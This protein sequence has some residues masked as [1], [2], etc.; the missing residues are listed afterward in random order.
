MEIVI[1]GGGL[2]G[3]A[4]GYQLSRLGARRITIIEREPTCGFHSSGRNAAM[5]RQITPLPQVTALASASV[6]FFSSPPADWQTQLA[7]RQTG[8]LLLASGDGIAKLEREAAYAR[9]CGIPVEFWSPERA[10]AHVPPLGGAVFE[11]AV[12]SP[13]DGVLDVHALLEGYL[14]G[15]RA[16]GGRVATALTVIGFA[17]EG[18]RITA[19][20][21]TE[22]E[23]RAD[24]V[25]NAAGAWAGETGHLA[26]AASV[27]L[28]PCRRHL[29]A[30]G[31]LADV[32]P[33]WPFVW[34]VSHEFYFRPESGG[35]LF[36]PCDEE[37]YR[38]CDPPAD[39]AAQLLLAEKLARFAPRLTE[40]PIRRTW[41]GLRTLAPDGRFVIGWDGKITNFLWV[42]GLGGHGVTTSPAC[43]E[44][45]AR[46]VVGQEVASALPF[47]PARFI[48]SD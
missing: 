4:T 14:R 21:T 15:V 42:A 37:E 40:Y 29:L 11:S 33:D 41:A 2:A 17:T 20:R 44:I 1:I 28:R 9:D 38:P 43:S 46:L 30:A 45:A 13:T 27:P 19:V 26:G 16:V 34:D 6:R 8:S 12:W 31:P 32:N 23:L 25:V 39:P 7:F 10:V 24:V 3:A 47:A 48:K 35:L 5:I 22:G 36:S 18:S